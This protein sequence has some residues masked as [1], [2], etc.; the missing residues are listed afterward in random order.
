MRIMGNNAM[1]IASLNGNI[2]QQNAKNE[3]NER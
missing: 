1:N 2:E 3:E